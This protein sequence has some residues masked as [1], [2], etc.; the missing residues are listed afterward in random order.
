MQRQSQPQG[1]DTDGIQ[2]SVEKRRKAKSCC[3]GFLFFYITICLGREMQGKD[4]RHN[5]SITSLPYHHNAFHLF[6]FYPLTFFLNPACFFLFL[7]I[8]SFLCWLGIQ[9]GFFL[10]FFLIHNIRHGLGRT[11]QGWAG[12]GGVFYYCFFMCLFALRS[13]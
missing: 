7:W 1:R 2:V 12:L 8:L 4:S 13:Y 9:W 11:G 6:S 5:N 3:I 10:S